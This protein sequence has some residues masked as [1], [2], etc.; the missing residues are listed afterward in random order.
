MDKIACSRESLVPE[1]ICWEY[2]AHIPLLGGYFCLDNLIGVAKNK[3]IYPARSDE[4]L[5]SIRAV[6]LDFFFP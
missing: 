4:N 2:H 3:R 5:K 1:K 6:V